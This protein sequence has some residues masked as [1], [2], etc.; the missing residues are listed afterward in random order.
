MVRGNIPQFRIAGAHAGEM[1]IDAVANLMGEKA[2]Q[3]R[4]REPGNENR[5]PEK[6]PP[7]RGSGFESM[8]LH[9]FEIQQA[10][11]IEW[12]CHN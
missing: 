9:N 4:V 5:I 11:P 8:G 10:N 3:S 6:P 1:L 2:A 12:A 7:V